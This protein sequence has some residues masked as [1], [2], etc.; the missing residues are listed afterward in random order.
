MKMDMAADAE[1]VKLEEAMLAKAGF[2][3]AT[4][5]G[6]SFSVVLFHRLTS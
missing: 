3:R 2:A 5:G 4:N 1:A 6:E